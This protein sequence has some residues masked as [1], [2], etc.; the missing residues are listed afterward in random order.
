MIFLIIISTRI[1]YA[2]S[3]N[4]KSLELGN[5]WV[6]YVNGI[7]VEKHY[8]SDE[9]IGDT[10]INNKKYA[11]IL[12]NSLFLRYERADSLRIFRFDTEDSTETVIADFSLDVDDSLNSS[13]VTSKGSISI[14]GRTFTEICLFYEIWGLYFEKECYTEIGR[15]HV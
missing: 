5:Q 7:F 13:V 3:G 2:Q 1:I 8:R 9:V 6:Y 4:A 14:W 15:A 12:E 10:I 11:V